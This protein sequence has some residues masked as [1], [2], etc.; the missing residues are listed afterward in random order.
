M[1]TLQ[2]R[3][4]YAC[5]L[6]IVN[7]ITLIL[8]QLSLPISLVT[9]ISSI[10][11]IAILE[12]FGKPFI[13]KD[14]NEISPKRI[15]KKTIKILK[16]YESIKTDEIKE[17]EAVL[18]LGKLFINFEKLGFSREGQHTF[19]NLEYEIHVTGNLP[20]ITQF[21]IRK[22]DN[23]RRQSSDVAFFSNRYGSEGQ[24]QVLNSFIDYFK[25]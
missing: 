11:F 16:N 6:I 14:N 2:F 18:E 1:R 25:D 19:K 12:N 9:G 10:I 23:G 5:V 3:L 7:I 22:L 15:K 20:N 4:I 17:R 21:L 13:E 8:S 24:I